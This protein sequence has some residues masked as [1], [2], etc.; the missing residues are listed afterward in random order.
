MN[1]PVVIHRN[2]L[3][4]I[5]GISIDGVWH[6]AGIVKD[7]R[8]NEL[9]NN[10]LPKKLSLSWVSL[11]NNNDLVP[12][13]HPI[14]SYVAI[15]LSDA[16]LIG[17]RK[18]A[19]KTG[20]TV[21]I[22]KFYVHGFSQGSSPMSF[23]GLSWN[24]TQNHLFGS[25]ENLVFFDVPPTRPKTGIIQI[26]NSYLNK[27]LDMFPESPIQLVGISLK[28]NEQIEFSPKKNTWMVIPDF[29]IREFNSNTNFD[30]GDF[31]SLQEHSLLLKNMN[32]IESSV[33]LLI[34]T[35]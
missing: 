1:K 22:P 16:H 35:D 21:K 11:K 7:L 18:A 13:Y 17:D 4:E 15:L 10:F 2:D 31:V 12:H 25:N 19:L 24:R 5:N 23:W 3:V 30:A 32:V 28:P 6:D 29:G 20:E 8:S 33:F 27:N 9:M 34:V 26:S 14:D